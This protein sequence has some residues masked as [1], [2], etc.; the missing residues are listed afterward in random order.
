MI[1]GT[2]NLVN[3]TASPITVILTVDQPNLVLESEGC[4]RTHEE[5]HPIESIGPI[6]VCD[7]SY[8]I[9]DGLPE[10]APD[11][12]YIVSATVADA[13]RG[14]RSDLLVVTDPVRD[15]DGRPIGWRG[16]RRLV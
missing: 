6:P 2:K 4:A 3:L 1:I 7:T 13:M 9:I 16:F 5:K 10:E 12:W 11:T 8:D 15:D 14:K